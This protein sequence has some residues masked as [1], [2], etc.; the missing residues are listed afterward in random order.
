MCNNDLKVVN[1]RTPGGNYRARH[2]AAGCLKIFVCAQRLAQLN[3]KLK[4]NQELVIGLTKK[5]DS[6]YPEN[7][8]ICIFSVLI[9]RRNYRIWQK[10]APTV[11]FQFCTNE[12]P[13]FRAFSLL[14]LFISAR[15]SM[16]MLNPFKNSINSLHIKFA[17]VNLLQFNV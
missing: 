12:K 8:T 17:A 1:I 13:S 16:Q 4:K 14:G 15:F 2:K 11:D 10:S 3:L 7:N 6:V 9:S 5:R